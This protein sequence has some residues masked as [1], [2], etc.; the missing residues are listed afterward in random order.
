MPAALVACDIRGK[1]GKRALVTVCLRKTQLSL[2]QEHALDLGVWKSRAITPVDEFVTKKKKEPGKTMEPAQ[3]K[4]LST[5]TLGFI[6]L[7]AVTAVFLTPLAIV[8]AG[9][10]SQ[11]LLFTTL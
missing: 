7:A 1:Q 9:T 8:M 3:H 11:Q 6:G 4:P 10:P 2:A 5:L